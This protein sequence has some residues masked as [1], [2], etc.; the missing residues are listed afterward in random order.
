MI[1]CL[2]VDD[3]PI[4]RQILE[5]YCG[6]LPEL[7]IVASCDNALKAKQIL[8]KDS[9][10][11]IF[12]DIDM[13][14]LNG[15]AF[16]KT[17]RQTPV[18]IFTTAY[19]QFAH[20]AFDINA[21]DYLLKPFSVERFIMAV[22]KAK[23][24]LVKDSPGVQMPATDSFI[25][26]RSEG[27]IFKIDFEVL[28]YAEARGNHVKI[29]LDDRQFTTSMTFASFE[30]LLPRSKFTRVH[31]SFIINKTKINLIEG[32]RIMI[33]KQEIP[34]G[35]NYRDQFFIEIGIK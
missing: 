1:K 16:I 33:N 21:C 22:D 9:I 5:T 25:Y 2:I 7:E 13:P 27:K 24:K 26:V 12:T 19:K 23:Q 8:E 30:E 34:I 28:Q 20:E 15:L 29:V 4:A 11:L 6:Y 3:E 35:S 31:R 32:N 17:L 14:I 10:D 18:V